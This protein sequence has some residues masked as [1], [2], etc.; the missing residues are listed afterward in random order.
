MFFSITIPAYKPL[1]LREAIESCLSQTYTDF[2]LII[3]DDAS[4]YDLISIVK[5]FEDSRVHY[6]K[7]KTNCGAINV[8]DNWNKC[9]GYCTGKYVICMGD[10]DR[11]L[12]NCLEEYSKLIDKYPNLGVYHAWTEI[13]DENG[14]VSDITTARPEYETVYSMLWHR[15]KGR[16]QYIGDFCFDTQQLRNAG[17]FYKLPLAWSS[18][19]I[20]ALIA[21]KES[22]VANT[23]TPTFQYRINRFTISNVGN[24]DEKLN[25][26]QQSQ[27]WY[28]QFLQE[29]PNDNID[30]IFWTL[31][32]EMFDKHFEM[33][34]YNAIQ[35]D[36]IGKNMFRIMYWY[37]RRKKY[38]LNLKIFMRLFKD[39]LVK[40]FK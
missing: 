5:Q 38:N 40:P 29:K 22:G 1:F 25:A 37:K 32:N 30:N 11:L 33:M 6:Y 18:D 21:A 28:N 15:W 2:E 35:Q 17:G 36:M 8:V 16:M 3:V 39:V 12:P 10:D 7:N 20:S 34:K 23:Q 9:L 31:I 13:I 26:I 24:A 4:P 14:S 27:Q 19:E